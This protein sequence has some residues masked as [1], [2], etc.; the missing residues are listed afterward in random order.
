MA[1]EFAKTLGFDPSLPLPC[2]RK[3]SEL[4]GFV[5]DKDAHSK[6]IPDRCRWNGI[7]RINDKQV[8]ITLGSFGE[9]ITNIKVGRESW[10]LSETGRQLAL[11]NHS[12]VGVRSTIDSGVSADK[13]MEFISIMDCIKRSR[14]PL[15][16]LELK[17]KMFD[18]NFTSSNPFKRPLYTI[19]DIS[20]ELTE[21]LIEYEN[22]RSTHA[23]HLRR[24][25]DLAAGINFMLRF[26]NI[27]ET[28]E[29][30]PD[31]YR[32]IVDIEV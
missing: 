2:L 26:G 16:K 12:I 5:F 9:W 24:F 18:S 31:P 11:E 32:S 28:A 23:S 20:F 29:P 17:N 7:S 19:G 14:L 13:G 22:E 25:P 6:G 30:L 1:A 21:E 15:I 27:L 10:T 8:K 3:F 4:S